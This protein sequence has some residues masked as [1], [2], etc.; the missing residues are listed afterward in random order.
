MLPHV[1]AQDV[2]DLRALVLRRHPEARQQLLLARVL[3]ALD[4]PAHGEALE[5]ELDLALTRA[6]ARGR[7]QRGVGGARRRRHRAPQLQAVL[8]RRRCP[9]LLTLAPP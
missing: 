3:D 1:A 2:P 7:G 8:G 4:R 9:E 6:L 5:E